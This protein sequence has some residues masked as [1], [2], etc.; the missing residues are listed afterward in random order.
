M[1]RKREI[2]KDIERERAKARQG[3]CQVSKKDGQNKL[4]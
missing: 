3:Q 4:G 1:Q 2:E